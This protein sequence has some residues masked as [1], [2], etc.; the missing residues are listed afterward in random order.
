M[1]LSYY[2]RILFISLLSYILLI[3]FYKVFLINDKPSFQSKSNISLKLPL[4]RAK[5]EGTVKSYPQKSGKRFRFNL[6]VNKINGEK[7]KN[8]IIVYLNNSSDINFRD[9][10]LLTGDIRA[11]F[12]DSVPGN[13][14]W[15]E[16]LRIRGINGR[17]LNP[18]IKVLEKAG[19]I[20]RLSRNIH[21]HILKVFNEEFESDYS[22]VVSGLVINE[23]FNRY[24]SALLRRQ[25]ILL[26]LLIVF[27]LSSYSECNPYNC[28]T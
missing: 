13:I 5:V 25:V 24:F 3:V 9:R 1:P 20:F 6:A 14:N 18:K 28:S 19:F 11:V 27:N 17:M 2:K 26:M 15:K 23:K 4:K 16:Y 12:S 8:G 10:I 22:I 7:T 21:G